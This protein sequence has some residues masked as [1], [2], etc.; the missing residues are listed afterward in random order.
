MIGCW[1]LGWGHV[2]AERRLPIGFLS[3]HVTAATVHV[4]SRV[5]SITPALS[6]SWTFTCRVSRQLDV[7]L[8]FVFLSPVLCLFPAALFHYFLSFSVVFLPLSVSPVTLS[9]GLPASGFS[10]SPNIYLCRLTNIYPISPDFEPRA[11]LSVSL[12][13][14]IGL[15][16]ND[17]SVYHSCHLISDVARCSVKHTTHFS[18]VS[19][20]F[21]ISI[22]FPL[23]KQIKSQ[24]S[25][26]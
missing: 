16:Q 1:W 2:P 11:M 18:F 15:R 4:L 3:A 9:H 21:S 5:S 22:F 13:I 20:H 7:S 26:A 19:L 24:A 8:L 10:P 23:Q 14:I 12:P 6:S 25:L 17:L